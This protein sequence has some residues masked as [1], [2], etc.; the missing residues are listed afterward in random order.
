MTGRPSRSSNSDARQRP[1]AWAYLWWAATGALSGFGA[2]GIL[3]IGIFLLLPAAALGMAGGLWRPLRNHSVMGFVG[4]LA[5]APLY[6]AWLNRKG[7]GTVC[8]TSEVGVTS[9]AER[10]N[11]WVFLVVGAVLVAVSFLA[12]AQARRV[13]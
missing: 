11:P 1:R 6:V 4:G 8:E 7:P 12:S 9:C 5:T 2:V 10:W 13:R 3:T